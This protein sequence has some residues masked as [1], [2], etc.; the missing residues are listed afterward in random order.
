MPARAVGR[1]FGCL[2]GTLPRV[3]SRPFARFALVAGL[4]AMLVGLR[5]IRATAPATLVKDINQTAWLAPSYLDPRRLT[6]AGGYTFF[7]GSDPHNGEELWATDGTAAGTRLLL[8]ITPG[9]EDS[10]FHDLAAVDQTLFFS[11]HF[12]LWKSD[13]TSSGT[14]FIAKVVGATMLTDVQGTLFFAASNGRGSSALWKSDGTPGGTVMLVDIVPRRLAHVDGKLVFIVDDTTHG[15]ELWV[16]DGTPGGTRMVKEFTPSSGALNWPSEPDFTV[17]GD[18]LFFVPALPNQPRHLWMSDGTEA[19]TRRVSDAVY[20]VAE[21]AKVDDALFFRGVQSTGSTGATTTSLWKTVSGAGGTVAVEPFYSVTGGSGFASKLQGAGDTLFFSG[22]GGLWASK[23]T[24][25]TTHALGDVEY[26]PYDEARTGVD[27][28]GTFFFSGRSAGD[29]ELWASDGTPEGTRQVKNINPDWSSEPWFM[30][31]ANGILLFAAPPGTTGFRTLWTSDGTEA[32]TRPLPRPERTDSAFDRD[33]GVQVK[34]ISERLFFVADDGVHGRELWISDGT[35]AGTRLVKDVNPGGGSSPSFLIYLNGTLYFDVFDGTAEGLWTS[36]GTPDGTS[37]IKSFDAPTYIRH[38]L[39]AGGDLFFFTRNDDVHALWRSDG[40]PE[41]TVKVADLPHNA[42]PHNVASVGGRL[43]FGAIDEEHGTEIWTSDGTTA[44]TKLLK[45]VAPGAYNSDPLGLTDVE[46]ILFF[47]ARPYNG[48]VELWKSDGTTE[49]TERV[50]RISHSYGQPYPDNMTAVGDRLFFTAFDEQAGVE[51]WTSDG[52]E[53]GTRRVKDINTTP[54][55]DIDVE[56]V[57][58]SAWPDDLANAGGVLLFTA[59]DGIHGRE[60]WRS[61]GTAAGT[62]LVD[63]LN[64]GRIGSAAGNIIAAG[65]NGSALFSA[66]DGRTGV[67][68]WRTDS[69]GAS[70][71][72]ADIATGAPSS[73]PVAFTVAGGNVFVVADDGVTGDELRMVSVNSSAATNTPTTTLTATATTTSTSTAMP[74]NTPTATATPTDTTPSSATG[75]P[76]ASATAT[77]T[78]VGE[79]SMPR[80]QVYLPLFGSSR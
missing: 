30:V 80:R 47:I 65:T 1:L 78:P 56:S 38:L 8:D 22:T 75:T 35:P 72:V 7:T 68:V 19:G 31:D 59:V 43:F 9:P 23:G 27:V 17:V 40:T 76:T 14:R 25:E 50:K 39:N 70:T 36:D 13:G 66:S 29:V 16:S 2:I 3:G 51:L 62:L 32:G 57:N 20:G 11:G 64:P 42:L 48:F 41:G 69:S 10:Y 5:P 77:S 52:T 33:N 18:K 49:G 53:D 4:C 79:P 74:T 60:L 15:S 46:G 26:T 54:N 55:A 28:G 58:A 67:E 45:D 37:L 61:D 34:A 12:G 24:A 21:L 63:D 71:L 73:N 6:V 44:G